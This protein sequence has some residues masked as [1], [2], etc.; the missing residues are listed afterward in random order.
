MKVGIIGCGKRFTNIYSYILKSL[1]YEVFLWNRT[2]QKSIEIS[3]KE[4]FN[5]VES[6][7]D[8][9]KIRPDVILCFIPSQAHFDIVNQIQNISCKIL[10]ETPG[11]DVR[12][13]SMKNIGVLEQWPKLP[14]EQFKEII[15]SSELI[16]R[17][18]MVQNDGRSFDYHAMAQLR[19][20][21]N[22]A[23][24]VVAKGSVK[25][26]PNL[27]QLDNQNKLNTTPHE[28][29][30]GQIEMSNGSLLL[31]NFAYNCKSLSSIPIQLLRAYSSD[32]CIVTGRMKQLGNDYEHI[33]IRYVN[34][35]TKETIFANVHVEKTGNTIASLSIENERIVWKNPYSHLNFDD[36]QTA[37][38]S[39][40]D[41]AIKEKTYS[42]QNAYIDNACINMIKQA[43]FQQQVLVAK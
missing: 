37:M 40:I 38:A 27:G 29:T 36:Q 10:F 13:A 5:H 18:Y 22:F 3:Q 7:Q 35:S 24:P 17:P 8:F 31:Y 42:Y 28:W 34:K 30:I 19:K 11:E 2:R 39:L 20:Y 14:L 32:G 16:S 6:I 15:Y 23:N 33:D 26:Y 25:S 9:Q 21:L 12:I 43:G 41:D 4:N 1:K